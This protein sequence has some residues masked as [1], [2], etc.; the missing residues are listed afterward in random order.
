MITQITDYIRR[1]IALLPAQH[2][3]KTNIVEFLSAFSNAMQSAEDGL[4]PLFTNRTLET[5]V[6]EQL[7]IIGRIVLEDRGGLDDDTY[8][9]RLQA[10][11]ATNKSEGTLEEL[12]NIVALI[13]LP[14][15]ATT[16][17]TMF[18]PAAIVFDVLD[19]SVDSSLA[20]T[21]ARFLR[22]GTAA[23]VKVQVVTSESAQS[24]VLYTSRSA[25]IT[26][27]GAGPGAGVGTLQ[28]DDT[29]G[30]PFVGSIKIDTGMASQETLTYTARTATSIVL[31]GVT[32]FAHFAGSDVSL[33][34]SLGKGLGNTDVPAQGGNI[35]SV[36]EF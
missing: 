26:G 32:G 28:V 14:N 25:Y 24:D 20:D 29:T 21:L 1:A 3:D 8:R 12:L 10:R 13:L 5:A 22:D 23:G 7:D 11:I 6:G 31:S 2:Q 36:T 9:I 4:F 16:Q 34:G 17:A 30:F 35:S 15:T 19:L 27:P 18:F 33:V